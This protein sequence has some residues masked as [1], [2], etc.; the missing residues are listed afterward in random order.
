MPNIESIPTPAVVVDLSIAKRNIDSLADYA[1]A[2]KLKVRPHTKT[3]KS[4][5]VAQMQLAAGAGGLTVAKPGEALVMANVCDDLLIAYPAFDPVR[6]P[7]VAALARSTTLRIAVDS[8]V[9]VDALAD[10]A[11]SAGSKIGI[12]IDFDAGFHRTGLQSAEQTLELAIR[13]TRHPQLSLDGVMFFPG[14][15]FR[16][17]D[18]QAEPLNAIASSIDQIAGLWSRS[19]LPVNIISG[20]STPTARNSHLIG[21]L[22]EIRPGT[23][24]YNDMNCVD[25]GYCAIEDCAAR[26]VCTVVSDAV[27]GKCVIDAGSKALTS[28]RRAVSPES[29][30]YGHVVELPG[31][32]IVRLSEEH[33]EIELNGERPPRLGSR[34]TVIPNHVCPCINLHD[35]VWYRDREGRLFQETVDARGRLQ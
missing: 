1:N 16:P 6:A 2:H 27:P 24:V 31:A 3:H 35:S 7:V 30:S 19:G 5:R 13:V 34:L 10:A 15:V 12:L 17:V 22:T 9:A 29:A 11:R 33:G 28:D 21:K 32:R 14:H 4:K 26:V 23:Y 8:P 20:G 25:G 18:Q